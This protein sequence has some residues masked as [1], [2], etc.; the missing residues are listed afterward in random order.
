MGAQPR[1]RPPARLQGARGAVTARAAGRVARPRGARVD[2]RRSRG[3]L[4][5]ML[6]ERDVVIEPGEAVRVLDVEPHWF[7][8]VDGPVELIADLRAARGA[9]ASAGVRRPA[10][11]CGNLRSA[12]DSVTVHTSASQAPPPGRPRRRR[13]P[14]RLRHRRSAGPDPDRRPRPPRRRSDGHLRRRPHRDRPRRGHRHRPRRRDPRGRTHRRI[15][16]V[17]WERTA[18]ARRAGVR[19]CQPRRARAAGRRSGSSPRPGARSAGRAGAG[20]PGSIEHTAPLPRGSSGGPLVDHDGRLLGLNAVR[21]E[22]GL[23]LA[24]PVDEARTQVDALARGRAAERPRLGVALAHPRA[25]RK[26]R[27]AVG[28]PERDGLLVRAVVDGSPAAAARARSSGDLLVA[29]GGQP[30]HVGRRPVR[31]ARERGSDADAARAAR[32][33]RARRRVALG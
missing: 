10:T 26:L 17:A 30:L 29:V 11:G 1:D 21:R 5:L 9:G 24:V 33:R 8:A 27:A 28:L 19:A 14:P 23:I 18:D 31:R 25:A 6:G 7:G 13:P 16:P 32:D 20:S 15:P 2:V 12:S 4:R 22:G 3:R